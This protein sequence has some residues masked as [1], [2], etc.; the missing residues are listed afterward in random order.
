MAYDF[1]LLNWQQNVKLIKAGSYEQYD[2]VGAQPFIVL[3]NKRYN[4]LSQSG[5]A[6][7]LKAIANEPAALFPDALVQPA[8]VEWVRMDAITY[9]TTWS[10]LMYVD[11]AYD[12]N[13]AAVQATPTAPTFRTA[14]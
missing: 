7:A 10:Y 13:L 3:A 4:I 9:K 11:D 8:E 14:P 12:P 6:I 2:F 5:F 1:R